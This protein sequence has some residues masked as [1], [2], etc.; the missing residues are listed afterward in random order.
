MSPPPLA[1][2]WK[3]SVPSRAIVTKTWL[4]GPLGA[5]STW[6]GSLHASPVRVTYQVSK[7]VASLPD[8]GRFELK[9]SR[10]PAANG[11]T[12]RNAPV[13]NGSAAAGCHAPLAN[14]DDRITSL[15]RSAL[16]RSKYAVLPSAENEIANSG[17]SVDTAPAANTRGLVIGSAVAYAGGAAGLG[18]VSTA[19]EP[20][21]ATRRIANIAL[22]MTAS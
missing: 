18:A 6:T 1:S 19:L 10:S 3:Y 5:P 8:R 4:P 12:S 2:D 21:H 13:E 14:T 22:R 20:P 16:A 17:S 7:S 9:Y 15:L 11:S